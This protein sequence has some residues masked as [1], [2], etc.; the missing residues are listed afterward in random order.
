MGERNFLPRENCMGCIFGVLRKPPRQLALQ[1]T[2]KKKLFFRGKKMGHKC[3]VGSTSSQTEKIEG[4]RNNCWATPQKRAEK[5]SQ[6][7]Q[8]LFIFHDL[9][10]G[11]LS[12]VGNVTRDYPPYSTFRFFELKITHI[13]FFFPSLK[14]AGLAS[15]H[16]KRQRVRKSRTRHFWVRAFSFFLSHSV[17][18]HNCRQ[19]K[20]PCA[21]LRSIKHSYMGVKKR[22][23]YSQI[24]KRRK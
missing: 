7:H 18:A 15:F 14:N 6:S 12:G 20:G 19:K 24:R 8:N 22:G 1:L 3:F 9:W 21:F 11:P 16:F 2:R 5:S 10:G 4:R 23:K 17:L 13:I